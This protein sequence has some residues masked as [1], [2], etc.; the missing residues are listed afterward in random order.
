M[1]TSQDT[2][3]EVEPE[4]L[5]DAPSDGAAPPDKAPADE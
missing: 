3:A 1:E 5:P 4:E 2:S